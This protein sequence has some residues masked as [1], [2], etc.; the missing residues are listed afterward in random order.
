MAS[1]SYNAWCRSNEG[2]AGGRRLTLILHVQP[3]AKRTEVVGL[4]GDALKIRLAAPPLEGA[5]NAALLAFLA[6]VFGVPQRH[7][8]LKRGNKSRRKVIEIMQAVRGPEALF[9]KISRPG[10]N[11]SLQSIS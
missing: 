10:K 7:V 4:R 5:A 6:E 11:Q 3:G 1:S 2:G 8:M 9:K